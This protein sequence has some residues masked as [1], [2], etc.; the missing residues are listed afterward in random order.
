MRLVER[1]TRMDNGTITYRLTVSDPNTFSRPWTL[2]N[3]LWRTDE[4]I[5][6]AACHEG[7]LGIASILAGA[8]AAEKR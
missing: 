3:L 4:P 7:N 1:F 2:E 6:E 5:F 8:R